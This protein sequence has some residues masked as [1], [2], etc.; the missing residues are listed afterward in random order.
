M[1]YTLLFV[2]IILIAIE[3][4]TQSVNPCPPNVD[5]ELGNLSNW[6]FYTGTC[7]PIAT[8]LPGLPVNGR[9]TLMSGNGLD[10][11][12]NFPVV[13]PGGGNYSLKLGNANTGSES[14]RAR[15]YVKVPAG[16]NNF[17]LIY[18]YAVVFED[19]NHLIQEQPRFEVK[20]SDSITGAIYPCLTFTYIAAS[21]LPGFQSYTFN[22]DIKYKSWTTASLNLSGLGGTTVAVDFASGDCDL[23]GHFGYGYV[24]MACGLFQIAGTLCDNSPN[25]TLLGPSGF[26]SYDWYDSSF[27]NL[28]GS[29]Q[30]ITL[31]N[32]GQNTTYKLV[33]SPFTGFGCPDTLTTTLGIGS[34]NFGSITKTICSGES[35]LGHNASGTY[36]DT[37]VNASGC[38]SIHTTILNVLPAP[39]TTINQSICNGESYLGYTNAGTYIDTFVSITG[40]DSLRILN[41]SVNSV[42]TR[43]STVFKCAENS[44]VVNG[45]L[46]NAPAQHTFSYITSSGCDSFLNVTILNYLPKNLDLGPNFSFCKGQQYTLSAPGYMNY[47]WSTGSTENFISVT[48]AGVY[49]LN[50]IDSNNCKY[51]DEVSCTVNPSPNVTISPDIVELCKNEKIEFQALGAPRYRWYRNSYSDFVGDANNYIFSTKENARIILEG[52][53][54][55]NC[56][57]SD[58]AQVNIVSCCE[59]VVFPNAFS[60]NG[61][62]KNDFFRPV[63]TIRYSDYMCI[64]ADRWGNVVFQSNTDQIGWEGNFKGEKCEVGTY[65]YLVKVKCMDSDKVELYKGDI[66]LIR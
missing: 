13:A 40:C 29:G 31:S 59:N 5:F 34:F 7:C 16:A 63:G 44:V 51:Y 32:P 55:F 36:V 56:S 53:N 65:F 61:D 27:T 38:D 21:N 57:G 9:H 26:Q 19:P 22:P 47:N 45:L 37:L 35:Y 6:K 42:F 41:L 48:N 28:L 58:T 49:F 43:D 10:P 4:F 20:V 24:D 46:F 33:I 11:Y 17:S 60:P 2:I 23:G 62:N 15:Y 66:L 64:I 18:R 25:F 50:A 52:F 14:E 12:G 3:G 54:D 39:S 8:G 1:K 30:S